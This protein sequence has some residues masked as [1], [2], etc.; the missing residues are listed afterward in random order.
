MA[1]MESATAIPRTC[2]I[3]IFKTTYENPAGCKSYGVK[4]LGG[5]ETSKDPDKIKVF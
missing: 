5:K 2:R 4:N 3:S 1:S